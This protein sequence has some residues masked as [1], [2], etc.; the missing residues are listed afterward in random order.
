MT[1]SA[2]MNTVKY[3]WTITISSE[4]NKGFEGWVLKGL[5]CD[6]LFILWSFPAS[7]MNS[8]IN[9]PPPFSLTALRETSSLHPLDPPGGML[10]D[11]DMRRKPKSWP[12]TRSAPLIM[13]GPWIS[14]EII[15][16]GLGHAVSLCTDFL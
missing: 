10:I 2:S 8:S 14:L 16:R 3:T 9:Y 13:K 12:P 11:F 4:L 5:L 7:L 1:R 6:R 15:R